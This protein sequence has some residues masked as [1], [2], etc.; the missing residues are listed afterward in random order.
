[1]G[2]YI[3]NMKLPDDET[4]YMAIVRLSKKC[5]AFDHLTDDYIGEVIEVSEPHG[6]LIDE[7]ELGE[8]IHR[9]WVARQITNTKYNTFNDILGIVPTVIEAEE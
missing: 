1:M 7:D 5:G 6:R 8:L 2:V 3:K 4:V 9:M